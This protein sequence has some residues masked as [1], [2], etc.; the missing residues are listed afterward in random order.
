MNTA[1]Q[2]A[3]AVLR[4]CL[5][6]PD[7][8]EAIAALEADIA[9]E[10]EPVAWIDGDCIVTFGHMKYGFIDRRDRAIPDSWKPLY[11]TPPEPV[12]NA[13]LLAA[14]TNLVKIIESAGVANLTRGV[15]LGQTVWFVKAS[16]GLEYAN[17]AIAKATS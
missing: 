6:H 5:D 7:A 3:L 9:Q 4:G 8:A 14:L 13:E 12:V 2:M 15:E 11:T 17:E 10:V 16:D 1:K